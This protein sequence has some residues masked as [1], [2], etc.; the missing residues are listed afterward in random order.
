MNADDIIIETTVD[1][2]DVMETE[3]V[4]LSIVI[5][6]YNVKYFLEQ[7]LLSIE[8]A[9]RGMDGLEVFVVDNASTDGSL[10]YLQPKFPNVEFIANP[11]NPGFARANNQA[12]RRARGKYVLML[13]P[14]TVVGEDC[15]RTLIY[16]MDERPEVGA[17][18]L[19]MLNGNG[20]FLRE[21]KRAFPTPWI[22]FCK[23]SGLS[24]LFPESP[25][26]AQ[27]ALPYLSEDEE[28]EVEVLAGAFMFM[29]REALERAG[30]LDERYFMYG[31]D[32]DLSHQI[33][34]AGYKNIYLPERLLHYKGESTRRDLAFVRRFYGAM[35]LFYEKYYPEQR[36]LGRFI[37]CGVYVLGGLSAVAKALGFPRKKKRKHRRLLIICR[38]E[39]YDAA[40]AE[41]LRSLRGLS[42]VKVWNLDENRTMEAIGRNIQMRQFTDIAFVWPDVRYEQMFLYM[43][44]MPNKTITY[45]IYNVKSARLVSP[46]E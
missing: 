3:E 37:R 26:Y 24:R 41:S 39:N 10:A 33:E 7:C 32:I 29:R 40:K 36:A 27:Y 45:H 5:V 43:D 17:V 6:N 35:L 28:H 16:Y 12:F 38:P 14:D 13:N 30:Y 44:K 18:G 2:E 46:G 34:L 4:V 31:E 8:A 23:L 22:S 25:K 21:S 15:L 19:K 1:E 42:L 9:T 11:D 20:V